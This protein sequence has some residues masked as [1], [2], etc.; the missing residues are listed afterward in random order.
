MKDSLNQIEKAD[1]R[2]KRLLVQALT[3]SQQE[4][5][6]DLSRVELEPGSASALLMRSSLGA[7]KEA[8]STA[9]HKRYLGELVR[10]FLAA[11]KPL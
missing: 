5:R 7:S 8:K 11:T 10:V 6:L 2:Y 9:E 4:G 3:Q 1:S